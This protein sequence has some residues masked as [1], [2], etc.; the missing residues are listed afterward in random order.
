MEHDAERRR[1]FEAEALPHADAL[2]RTALRLTP[3][4]S[5]AED[6]VQETYLKA[7]RAYDRFE[8][9]TNCRAWLFK[10][11]TNTGINQH[12]AR[13]RRPVSVDFDAIAA[14]AAAPEDSAVPEP[15]AGDWSVYAGVLDD[16]MHAA[17][18]A[19]PEP[20]RVVLVLAVLEG[21][22]YKE[23]AAMLALP[24]GTVMSRL[25][26]ARRMMQAALHAAARRRGVVRE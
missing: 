13:A 4:R 26:R 2:F 15:S 17:L 7:Y 12:Q 6:L 23:I 3:T 18:A 11:L 19:L 14:I 16:D 25:F 20:F 21:F 22:A 24:I 9:G 5:D 1:R 10:I 8:S